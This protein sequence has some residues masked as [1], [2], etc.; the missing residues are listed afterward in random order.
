MGIQLGNLDVYNFFDYAVNRECGGIVKY[1]NNQGF[2]I[3]SLSK[4]G[5]KSGN[6]LKRRYDISDIEPTYAFSIKERGY[7]KGDLETINTHAND[8]PINSIYSVPEKHNKLNFITEKDF[9]EFQKKIRESVDNGFEI[10]NPIEKNYD[11]MT[12]MSYMSWIDYLDSPVESSKKGSLYKV[13]FKDRGLVSDIFGKISYGA[14]KYADFFNKLVMTEIGRTK[15][16]SR[17]V[18]YYSASVKNSSAHFNDGVRKRV[19]EKLKTI[20]ETASNAHSH[21][22]FYVT[23]DK[24]HTFIFNKLSEIKSDVGG[25][26]HPFYY[27]GKKT[28]LQD[29]VKHI[30]PRFGILETYKETTKKY[31]SPLNGINYPT[32]LSEFKLWTK[33]N[34]YGIVGSKNENIDVYNTDNENKF[35]EVVISPDFKGTQS[36]LLKRTNELIKNAKLDISISTMRSEQIYKGDDT[37][38]YVTDKRRGWTPQ[39]PYKYMVDRIRPFRDLSLFE[40]QSNYGNMRPNGINNLTDHTVLKDNGYVRITPEHIGGGYSAIKNY[41]F[42]IEN[43]AW[44][45]SIKSLSIEQ[46]GPNRGRIMWFPPYNLRFSEN[47]NVNWN[48]NNFIGRGEGIHTYVNTTRSGTLDFTLLIDHPSIINK[49]RGTGDMP[50]ELGEKEREILDFFIGAR[51]LYVNEDKISKIGTDI[52][53]DRVR[54]KVGITPVPD[55][56]QTKIAYVIFFP[57]RFSG[58]G[59]DMA[60]TIDLLSKF[61][62]GETI[63]VKN[64]TD[65]DF[66][67]ENDVSCNGV[68]LEDVKDQIQKVVF[69]NDEKIDLKDF[70]EFLGFDKSFSGGTIFG[71]SSETCKVNEIKFYAYEAKHEGGTLTFDVLKNRRVETIDKIFSSVSTLLDKN[72]TKI[73]KNITPDYFGKSMGF[74]DSYSD[75]VFIN[76][77]ETKLMRLGIVELD[78]NWVEDTKAKTDGNYSGAFTNSDGSINEEALAREMVIQ[79]LKLT[80]YTYDNE[81]LYFSGLQGDSLEYK[82][83]IDK[84]KY[85]NPA[86]HSIT[87]EGFNARLTFL[88]QCTRQGPTNAISGGGV[89]TTSSD[90]Q[91]FAG[92]LAFGRAPYCVLRIG[93]FFNTK[94]CIDSISI[95]YDNGGVQWDLNP[96]GAG[97]QP[98]FA[99]VSISFKFI[100]GQDISGPIA[101]LQNAVTSNYYAN[102]SVYS[103]HADTKDEYFNVN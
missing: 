65:S 64:F 99:N 46:V 69:Q 35:T 28:L 5:S 101:R 103:M 17:D 40:T 102:A 12:S 30:E 6:K 94:I 50:D 24:T 70:N 84:V 3:N 58:H 61:N 48:E 8:G 59:N 2:L 45:D 1:T 97:V 31:T 66:K 76:S 51:N 47:V 87:P 96:E 67:I 36:T 56:I 38:E 22:L 63:N 98:M 57:H 23:F 83:I 91:K 79:M 20:D 18:P 77:N 52:I 90:Y 9:I 92:N 11:N 72:N 27:F 14:R 88:H 21:D 7:G 78:I 43:L 13:E 85:F 81:Y 26:L 55:T 53:K 68:K 100:G 49:W 29:E 15:G 95:S 42:S 74:I 16:Y 93:D 62:N 32:T 75:S 80:D 73:T 37:D 71:H 60:K 10:R 82:K 39:S 19:F 86:Y 33:K 89:N 41:M 44:R 25:S 4:N 54:D 34:P